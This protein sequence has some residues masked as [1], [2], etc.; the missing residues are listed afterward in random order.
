MPKLSEQ[1][2]ARVDAALQHPTF[3]DDRTPFK[4]WLLL[5]VILAVLVVITGVSFGIAAYPGFV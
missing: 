5:M 1:D 3:A 2:Q 4:P